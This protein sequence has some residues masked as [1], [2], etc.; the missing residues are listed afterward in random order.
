M[1]ILSAGQLSEITEHY[2]LANTPGFLFQK[3]RS[4]SSLYHRS[5]ELTTKE[6]IDRIDLLLTAVESPDELMELYGLII[7]LSYKAETAA[8]QAL[9]RYAMSTADWIG[10][11][12]TLANNAKV[13]ESALDLPMSKVNYDF[14]YYDLNSSNSTAEAE[15]KKEG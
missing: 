2:V 12:A 5:S 4:L 6:L 13:P 10:R 3:L 9:K 1:H 11:I 7:I 14:R 8:T 15:E